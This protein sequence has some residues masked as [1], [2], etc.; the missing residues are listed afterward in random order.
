MKNYLLLTLIITSSTVFAQSS[1]ALKDSLINAIGESNLECSIVYDDT[2]R[3]FKASSTDG[4]S[5]IVK[6]SFNITEDN[7][8]LEVSYKKNT[9]LS[10]IFSSKMKVVLSED[11]SKIDRITNTTYMTKT[12]KI[13]IGSITS[14]RYIYESS[15]KEVLS[16]ECE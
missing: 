11:L 3:N 10:N 6:Y 9:F 8:E 2:I 12:K 14:P 16:E 4:L 5:K 1:D 7:N 15:V 13:N